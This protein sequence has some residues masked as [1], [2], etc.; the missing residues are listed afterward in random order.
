MKSKF[1][2]VKCGTVGLQMLVHKKKDTR[3]LVLA[4]IILLSIAKKH[5]F[6]K[7]CEKKYQMSETG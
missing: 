7:D 4:L 3:S 2:D 1:I 5:Q 6:M